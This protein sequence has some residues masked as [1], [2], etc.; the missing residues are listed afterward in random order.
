M[1]GSEDV[2]A[3][4]EVT[5]TAGN[6]A[7]EASASSTPSTVIAA[8]TLGDLSPPR[9]AGTP[10]AGD[11]LVADPGE[12]S[13]ARPLSIG[14]QWR[15]CNSSGEACTNISGATSQRYTLGEA[16]VSHTLRIVVTASNGEGSTSAASA[17]SAT[18]KPG[19]GAGIRYLYDEA[20]RLKLVD[21]PSQGAAVYGWD[22]DGNLT[23]IQRTGKTTLAIL[24][25]TPPHAP[26]GAQ[27]DITGTGFDPEPANDA[28]SFDGVTA[29]IDT[30]SATD[31][32]V[33]VPEGASTGA[34][35]VTVGEES[36]ESPS[37]FTPHLAKRL[38]ASAAGLRRLSA[39]PA[40]AS[41]SPVAPLPAAAAK[42]T[43][44]R[45]PSPWTR[46]PALAAPRGRT[47]L[48]GQ[49]LTI[50]G[51]PLA[52]VTLEIEVD[53]KRASTDRS[54]R[55]VL[56]GVP[57][58]R[59]VLIIDGT[60]AGGRGRRFGRF[61]AA[62]ELVKGK[63]VALGYTIWMTPLDAAG[64]RTL[65]SPLK[66][67]TVLANPHIPGLEVHLPAGTVIHSSRGAVV[68]HVNLTAVP[69]DRPPFPL[70]L[71]ATGVPT[72]FTV[73]PG[74]AYLSKGAQIVY[75]NWGHLA[76]G[77]RVDFWNYDPDEEGWYVY[78]KGSVTAN[79]QQVVP[80]PGVR[81]WELSGAMITT[82]RPAPETGPKSGAE[83]NAGD[84]VDLATGL[85]VYQ[86]TDL[87]LPDSTMP[88]ALTR[89]YRPGDSNSYSF[90]VGAQSAFDI[91]LWSSENYKAAYLILPNGGKVKLV[92]TSAGTGYLEAEYATTATPGPWEGATMAWNSSASDWILRRRDGM[93]FIFGELAPLQAIE[94]RNGNRI[95]LVREGGATG[96]IVQIRAPH[97]R[98]I[99][100]DHDAGNRVTQATDS[101]GQSVRYAYDGS[102]RLV[103]VIDPI[104]RV[105]RY[106]YDSE[107]RMTKV[108]DARG[109]AL[110]ENAYAPGAG[111]PRVSA[112][113]IGGQGKYAFSYRVEGASLP[114]AETLHN[115]IRTVKDPDG[116]EREA[117]FD[118]STHLLSS[119]HVDGM[120]ISYRHDESGN[121]LAVSSPLGSVSYTRDALGNAT[122]VTE[123]PE[124]AAPLTTHLTYSEA[125]SEPTSVTD[126][127]GRITSYAYDT[128]GNPTAVTDPLGRQTMFGYDGEGERTSITDPE[129][130][131]TDFTYSHG[132]QVA[133]TDPLGHETQVSYDA[134]GQPV[135]I[136]DPEG[137]LTQLAYDQDNEPISATNPA[138]QTTGYAY[139][140]DGNLV[141]VTDPRGHT[142]EGTYNA[143]DELSSWTDAI[144]RTTSYGYDEL[145][146]L[147]SVTDPK[148]QTTSYT[149]D[150]L[151]RLSKVAFGAREGEPPTSTIAYGYDAAGNLSSVEDSR[152]GTYTLSHDADHRLTGESGPGG[153]VGYDYDADG[154]R[155]A[156]TIGAEEAAKYTYNE[157][158]QLAGVQTPNGNVSLGY[159]ADGR[160]SQTTL[161]DGDSESYTYEPNSDLAGIDYTTPEGAQIGS[162]QYGRD[163]LGRVTTISGSLARTNLPEAVSGLSYDDANELTSREGQ[164]LTY[165]EDGNLTGDGTSTYAYNDRNQLA[166]LT[167]GLNTW[168][169]AYDP[170]GRRTT[171]TKNGT[172]SDYLYDAGNVATE[173]TEGKTG[174]LLNGLGLDERYARTTSAGT[175]SYLTDELGSTVALADS[176]GEPTTEYTY[177][178]FGA[179]TSTG[180]SSTN[181]YQFTGRENDGTG[182]QYN[183][184]RYYDP[185]TTRFASQ[186][187]LGLAGSGVNLYAYTAEDPLNYTDL[188]G[189]SFLEEL[190]DGV[191]GFGDALSG[192]ITRDIRSELGLG[193]PDFSSGAYQGGF[194][195]GILAAV[196]VPGDEE[197]AAA[198]VAD[199]LDGSFS[200]FTRDESGVVNKYTT[201]GPA[202]P[203][204]PEE[205]RPTIRYDANGRSHFNKVTGKY[206]DTPHI[207]DPTAPG[208]VRGPTADESP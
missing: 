166:E 153:S 162:L 67:E 176:G 139:D 93:K 114:G 30:A 92:R 183:R 151:N 87:Q 204:D 119:E 79:G 21:D 31:L 20:G 167:Q 207:H 75:P 199:G 143:L 155:T 45:A 82:E 129:G 101:A 161:P 130:H 19:A 169:F 54:G 163:A 171:K 194:D 148:K 69:V 61:S 175:S 102:G 132:N 5:V 73:Q 97:G 25:V 41:A 206:V 68:R 124:S 120:S 118:P 22:E 152:A 100:L 9:I 60:S 7:G 146:D 134:V 135:G 88:V 203:R 164:T 62:V 196:L 34:I 2:G 105:T 43:G 117:V 72:Y 77:Q 165:D 85:F 66:R 110:I 84:P 157:A 4:V 170:F 28:V 3:T 173:T 99:Y 59:H 154:E 71:F 40:A 63:T 195:G 121:L 188:T 8:N 200:T 108:I 51:K 126:P 140:A 106:V 192:G 122:S 193:Q 184:A 172:A 86:H 18:I 111:P 202:D 181:P 95:T 113:T 52:H 15:R 208:G 56:S 186:D 147:T 70:P 53:R 58:G 187:P 49:A 90:G 1:L 23:S 24:A 198:D 123:E 145:G 142:Q 174:Q 190:G 98:W 201:Y 131:A 6:G 35:T 112:Q 89:T 65:R 55:F 128:N 37:E 11:T 46:L 133:V 141:S 80:D 29:S 42:R 191:T 14:Y 39:A 50:G 179:T 91:H 103:K 81:I 115:E 78:G 94:D 205:F 178:P 36:T 138:G 17:P 74:G 57:A 13:G 64:D 156:M 76:P 168:S 48:S 137:R 149:Y 150:A 33:T 12:W 127:M 125:F 26:P 189:Y 177:D 10:Q 38:Q 159:D 107:G 104:G 96:P 116:H 182:L 197:A 27:V 144:G 180:A 158:G 185:T 16:D 160:R 83:A 47:G 32:I 44:G 109:D 136:L